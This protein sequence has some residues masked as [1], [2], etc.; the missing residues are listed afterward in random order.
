M[1][2]VQ[3]II[4]N[5]YDLHSSNN[6]LINV[7]GGFFHSGI[8]I[9]G[10]EYSFSE[11]GIQRTPPRLPQFGTLRQQI[12]LGSFQ[13]TLTE[14]YTIIDNFST[15]RFSVGAYNVVSCNCNHFSDSLSMALLNIHIPDWVNRMAA[16]GNTILPGNVNNAEQSNGNLQSTADSTKGF[17][18]PGKVNSPE[19]K[20]VKFA[21]TTDSKNDNESYITSSIFNWLGWTVLSSSSPNPNVSKHESIDRT[22]TA[23]SSHKEIDNGKKKEL[24][25]KQKQLLTKLKDKSNS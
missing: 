13:G 11:Q 17:A 6:F 10:S 22:K 25:D 20:N 9:N 18:E 1:N 23:T 4:L 15:T 8:E 5:V 24:T 16:V 3:P 2:N 19:L 14:I 21:P 7:G 12:T